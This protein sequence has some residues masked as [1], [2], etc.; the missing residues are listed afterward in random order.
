MIFLHLTSIDQVLEHHC[1]GSVFV[2]DITTKLERR[3]LSF[4]LSLNVYFRIETSS[5]L[6][7]SSL[8]IIYVLALRA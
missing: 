3:V 2:K 4:V 7:S 5:S 8:E 1:P 6:A